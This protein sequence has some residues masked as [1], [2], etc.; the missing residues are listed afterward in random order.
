[1]EQD[2]KTGKAGF[3]FYDLDLKIIKYKC[4]WGFQFLQQ[5]ESL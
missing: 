5:N 1:M 2:P 3:A 4:L